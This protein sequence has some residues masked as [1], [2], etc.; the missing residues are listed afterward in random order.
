M[1]EQGTNQ[2]KFVFFFIFLIFK[3]KKLRF[4]GSTRTISSTTPKQN[5]A[6]LNLKKTKYLKNK[7]NKKPIR[8]W[9]ARRAGNR[10]KVD[11]RG[12]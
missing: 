10:V 7:K 5:R 11:V 3:K 2:A 1:S 6:F 8:F 12:P 9:E 4:L